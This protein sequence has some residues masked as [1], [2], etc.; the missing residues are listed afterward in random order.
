MKSSIVM[1]EV[2]SRC[3]MVKKSSASCIATALCIK[4]KAQRNQGILREYAASGEL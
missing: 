3:W 2:R 4:G 1:S